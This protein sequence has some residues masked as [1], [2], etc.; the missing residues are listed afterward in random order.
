MTAQELFVAVF[1]PFNRVGLAWEAVA[2]SDWPV[3]FRVTDARADVASWYF[4]W[5]LG[6]DGTAVDYLDPNGRPIE[7]GEWETLREFG[8]SFRRGDVDLQAARFREVS[9]R[10]DVDLE[11]A[12]FHELRAHV[13]VVVPAYALPNDRLL[14][15]DGNHRLAALMQETDLSF[16]CTA[17]ILGGPIN[18]AVLADLRHWA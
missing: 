17:V 13:Q 3:D 14:V 8:L 2:R 9:A 16:Q 12:R 10:G 6:P 7:I 4:P 11:A 18:E 1:A 5:Y 15:L